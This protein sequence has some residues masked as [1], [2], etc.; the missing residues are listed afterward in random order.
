MDTKVKMRH[1]VTGGEA[2]ASKSAFDK[3]YSGKGWVLSGE[4]EVPV[5]DDKV[6]DGKSDQVDR[7]EKTEKEKK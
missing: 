6:E 7:P 4:K 5:L 3:V 2:E 1:P